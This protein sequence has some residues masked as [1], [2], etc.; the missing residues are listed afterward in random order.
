MLVPNRHEATNEY[1]YGFNGHEKDD[2]IKGEGNSVDYGF[3]MHDPRAGR[4][5]AVDPLAEKH[6]EISPYVYT[7]N[8]PIRYIDPD[9]RDWVEGKNGS[10]TWRKDVNANNYSTVLKDG[11]TYRGT[12][13]ERA[14]N[15]DNGK[16]KGLVLEA[17]HTFG[18]MSYSPAKEVSINVEGKM[19]NSVIGDVD[20]SLN[21]TFE[22]GKTKTLGTYKAV[23]GGFG[24]GAPENGDYTI[25][26]YLDRGPKGLYNKG[27]N[28]DGIGFSYN[29]DPLFDTG[30]T[31]L[32][33]HPDGNKEG[34]LGC[35]GFAGNAMILTEFRDTLNSMLKVDKTIP[36]NI[37]ITNNP[38]NNGRSGKK[39]PKVNE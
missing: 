27:M 21:A 37:N 28:R 26:N 1:R 25:S 18:K 30:R 34:T 23:A 8:N 6:P 2:E 39:L 33:F 3:R 11:E 31:L 12:Y 9:G 14:K 4:W 7:A 10:I 16:H 20:V 17:Y 36:T 22:S 5:F 35:I 19:R 29:L 38:N 15:W 13:Y 32:R 24:N